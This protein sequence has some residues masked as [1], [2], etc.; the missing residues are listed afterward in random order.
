MALPFYND[1]GV[2][3]DAVHRIPQRFLYFNRK[4]HDRE[5]FWGL[6]AREQRS[7]AMT[8][9]YILL[10]MSWSIVFCVLYFLGKIDGD[11]QNPTTPFVISLTMLAM[12]MTYIMKN[13]D[14]S[15]TKID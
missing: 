2:S 12:L 9:L 3:A 6:M 10:S 7:S 8:V 4:L 14:A 5:W 11:I 13:E 1:Y 15:K